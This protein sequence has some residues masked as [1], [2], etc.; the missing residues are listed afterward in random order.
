MALWHETTDYSQSLFTGKKK[1]DFSED[2][3]YDVQISW[4]IFT[5][6]FFY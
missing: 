2:S 3:R 6:L 5:V 4:Q 1:T